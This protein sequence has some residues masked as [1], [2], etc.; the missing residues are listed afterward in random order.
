MS[1]LK[2]YDDFNVRYMTEGDRHCR[3]GWANTN[4]PFCTG[5]PGVHLGVQMDTWWFNCWRCGFHPAHEAIASLLGVSTRRARELISQYKDTQSFRAPS[6]VS[7]RHIKIK[8]FK[9]PTGTEHLSKLHVR[10]LRRR[11]F[12]PHKLVREWG[13]MGTGPISMLDHINYSHRLI[14]P[15]EWDG[16]EVSFQ[17]R[18]C[19]NKA[20]Q[21]YMACPMER[22]AVH[23]K[24][25]L[26]GKQDEWLDVGVCVE[27]ITDVWRMGPRT[28][29]T[30]GIQFAT[31]QVLVMM[32]VFKR[33]V[34]LFDSERQAQ[35]QA[36]KLAVKLRSAGV[37][38]HVEKILT[39][40]P[41]DMP[42][43]DADHLIREL[44]RKVH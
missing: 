37:S 6:K 25:I 12:D 31:E 29:A 20:M 16:K 23:H 4:C 2:L 1:I 32:K 43:D 7:N 42:Q 41:A 26:Y 10:Y 36:H 21:K 17:S 18:D 35:K 28:F 19:T 38:S 11:N 13:L 15:I 33:V 24:R 34:I 5:N 9:Y 30:F 44:T 14:A 3:P 22:E 39:G 40:D 27:G 8:P